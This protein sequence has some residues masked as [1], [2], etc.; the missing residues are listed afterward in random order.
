MRVDVFEN[1]S[2]TLSL[3]RTCGVVVHLLYLVVFYYCLFLFLFVSSL[4]GVCDTASKAC[5]CDAEWVGPACGQLNLVDPVEMFAAYPP[6]ALFNTTTSWG[7]S[8][9]NVSGQ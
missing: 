5:V 9:L 6:P 2:L 7:G 3:T 1:A 8:V 4:N